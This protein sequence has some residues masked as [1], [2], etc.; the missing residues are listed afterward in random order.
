MTLELL[1]TLD[2]G[3]KKAFTVELTRVEKPPPS[4]EKEDPIVVL[5][6]IPG[7]PLSCFFFITLQPRVE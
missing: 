1:R 7:A 3:A 6:P 5:P 4:K 2:M